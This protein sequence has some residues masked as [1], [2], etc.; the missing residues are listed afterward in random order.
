MHTGGGGGGGEGKYST[1]LWQISK[2]LLI[3]C[4]KTRNRGTPPPHRQFFLKAL[5][6]PRDFGKK[7][8][9]P[10]PLSFQPV[11]IHDYLEWEAAFSASPRRP[12]IVRQSS[13]GSAGFGR[14]TREW[15]RTWKTGWRSRLRCR[16]WPLKKSQKH[17]ALDRY[18]WLKTIV[19]QLKNSQS[20]AAFDDTRNQFFSTK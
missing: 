7:H 2:H 11:Y 3:N 19:C 20:H 15:R 5:T 1:P 14:S 18:N 10:P 12:C 4:N 17:S 6:P 13:P 8:Q 9:V 16:N